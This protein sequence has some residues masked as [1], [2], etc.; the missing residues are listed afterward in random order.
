MKDWNNVS[1]SNITKTSSTTTLLWWKNLKFPVNVLT[2]EKSTVIL[3]RL[4]VP[5][6]I[7]KSTV[8]NQSNKYV[9]TIFGLIVREQI[10]VVRKYDSVVKFQREVQYQSL[11][12]LIR[13]GFT[14][15]Y[16]SVSQS[17]LRSLYTVSPLRWSHLGT[18]LYL[19]LLCKSLDEHN[20][21]MY[22]TNCFTSTYTQYQIIHNKVIVIGFYNRLQKF[23]LI[24]HFFWITL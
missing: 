6:E 22:F 7:K 24:T 18:W 19:T 17:S 4:L 16:L 2:Q 9:T 14:R 5:F 1:D 21:L 8:R 12:N 15:L 20:I 10:K 3:V 23:C 13:Q 11:K